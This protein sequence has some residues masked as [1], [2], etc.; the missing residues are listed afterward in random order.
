MVLSRVE[1]CAEPG[2]V[3]HP[4]TVAL[5][6]HEA[7]YHHG[8]EHYHLEGISWFHKLLGQQLTRFSSSD[9]CW[10]RGHLDA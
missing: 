1:V 8:L 5:W 6:L 3:L 7:I 4:G 2:T 9:F 10:D